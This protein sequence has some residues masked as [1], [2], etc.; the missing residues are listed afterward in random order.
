MD[1]C[2]QATLCIIGL[3]CEADIILVF[4]HEQVSVEF[5]NSAIEEV[6]SHV[7]KLAF[8]NRVHS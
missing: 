2:S 6:I 1:P 3:E 5:L 7:Q 4:V 8:D